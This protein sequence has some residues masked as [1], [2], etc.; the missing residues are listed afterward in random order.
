M[1]HS[2]TIFRPTKA[3]EEDVDVAIITQIIAPI[4]K[5]RENEK[6]VIFD[7]CGGALKRKERTPDE[8]LIFCIDCSTSMNKACDFAE[9][10]NTDEDEDEVDDDDID[11]YDGWK[12]EYKYGF[13]DEDEGDDDDVFQR[14]L[15]D[16]DQE[17]EKTLRD[18]EIFRLTLS[19]TKRTSK[20][21]NAR[22]KL[23]P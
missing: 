19:G 21:F 3:E 1:H 16:D 7:S 23:K 22:L 6:C 4:L 5:A 2:I 11:E 18:K 9:F 20:T 13:E 12:D 14:N 17:S 15:P 8:I 10:E